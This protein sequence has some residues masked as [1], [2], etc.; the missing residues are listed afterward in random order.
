MTASSRAPTKPRF[1]HLI[2]GIL[3]TF[4]CLNAWV[5]I[6]LALMGGSDDPLLLRSWQFISGGAAGAAAIGAFRL[7][8]WAPHA[9]ITYGLITGTMIVALG[10]M[11]ELDRGE[12]GGLLVGAGAVALFCTGMAFYLMRL[13]R[14]TG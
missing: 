7:R 1:A 3:F 14:P 9:V 2:V 4:L 6:G 10:P 8:P 5:Q 12:R 11:L 13:V